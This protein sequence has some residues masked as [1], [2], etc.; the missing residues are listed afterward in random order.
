MPQNYISRRLTRR[1]RDSNIC[2]MMVMEEEAQQD[3]SAAS[4]ETSGQMDYERLERPGKDR[5]RWR[6][7]SPYGWPPPDR[8]TL[9]RFAA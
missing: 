1:L 8:V 5:K 7:S 2:A 6:V 3:E 9:Q 4:Q